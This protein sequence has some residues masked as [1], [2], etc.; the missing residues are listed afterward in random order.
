M[1]KEKKNDKKNRIVVIVLFCLLFLF[2]IG[3]TFAWF[4]FKGFSGNTNTLITGTTKEL[5]VRLDEYDGKTI[6]LLNTY[7]LTDASGIK[8]KAYEFSLVNHMNF[9]LN[10]KIQLILD[11]DAIKK[12]GCQDNL[13]DESVIRYQL[14]R[15]DSFVLID[16]LKNT[17]NWILDQEVIGASE[18]NHYSLRLWLAENAENEYMGKHFHASIKVD[19]VENS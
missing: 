7:P 4:R 1:N 17:D 12:C 5:E 10:Y 13:L 14:I 2:L 15:N 18:V 19:V 16:T 11:D 6:Q 3:I 9:K 8:T